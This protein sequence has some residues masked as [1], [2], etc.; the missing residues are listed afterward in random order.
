M[1]AAAVIGLASV[2]VVSAQTAATTLGSVRIPRA[3]EA[4]GE[5]LAAGTYTVRLADDAVT[6][7]VGE[8]PNSEHWVEF[9]QNGQV[10]GKELA[11]VVPSTEVRQVAES[12]PPTSGRVRVQQLKGSDYLRVW[13]NHGG[14]HYL[15]HL[16]TAKK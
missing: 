9:V 13:I 3:V 11:S 4:N 10:R 15:V 12:T 7:V 16:G 5:P 2:S 14:T 8:S 1:A 6:P